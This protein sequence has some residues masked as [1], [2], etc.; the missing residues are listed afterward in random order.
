M[1]DISSGI[2]PFL[3]L[4]AEQSWVSSVEEFEQAF[5]PVTRPQTKPQ[6]PPFC[7]DSNFAK[8]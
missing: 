6:N 5:L 1:V 3:P 7:R 4:V 2:C 8:V